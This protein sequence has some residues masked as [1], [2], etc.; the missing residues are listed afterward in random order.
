VLVLCQRVARWRVARRRMVLGGNSSLFSRSV[1]AAIGV[2]GGIRPCLRVVVVVGPVFGRLGGDDGGR[3]HR[4][5]AMVLYF[6]W[7]REGASSAVVV[8][9]DGPVFGGG[10]VVGRRTRIGVG[11]GVVVGDGG[12]PVFG[13]GCVGGGRR[14]SAMASAEASRRREVA[15]L[16][17]GPI[18]G[19]VARRRF[20]SDGGGRRI[21]WE[22]AS[23]FGGDDVVGWRVGGDWDVRRLASL[24][25]D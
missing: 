10:S 16:V 15:S 17:G 22:V 3:L 1:L 13:R 5:R 11:G 4:L 14:W 19:G 23:A 9:G 21:I 12:G 8:V 6:F 7:V 24:C 20:C 2:G 18:S 25:S